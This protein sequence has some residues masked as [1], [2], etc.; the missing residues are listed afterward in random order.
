MEGYKQLCVWQGTVVEDDSDISRQSEFVDWMSEEFGVR[1]IY[2]SE[3]KTNPN[4]NDSNT[5]GRNDLFFYVHDEDVAKFAIPRLKMGIRWWEDIFFN[6]Q[7][8]LYS[9]EFIAAHPTTW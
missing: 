2:E 8:Y 4:S 9:Q 7:E 1:V 6:E 3:Q 5:G